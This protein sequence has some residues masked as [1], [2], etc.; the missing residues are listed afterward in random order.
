MQTCVPSLLQTAQTLV[1]VFTVTVI[2]KMTP[3]SKFAS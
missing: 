1:C 3:A 2:E